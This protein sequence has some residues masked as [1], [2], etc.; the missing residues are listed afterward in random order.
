MP[1]R[2]GSAYGHRSVI[3]HRG[4]RDQDRILAEGMAD[5]S[6]M[7]CTRQA[8][9]ATGYYIDPE[10]WDGEAKTCCPPNPGI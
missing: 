7:E 3:D 2:D 5:G 10:F 8:L 9:R 6:P 4:T 1:G